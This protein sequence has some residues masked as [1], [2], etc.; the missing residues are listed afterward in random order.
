MVTVDYFSNFWEVDYLPDTKSTT[1][2]HKLKAHFAR[3]GIPDVLVSDNGP[4][5]TSQKFK[6][7][8]QKWEFEH[9][10]SSPGYPQSN[11]KAESAVKTAKRL[12]QRAAAAGQDPY[13]AILD[14]RN[15]PSQGLTTSPAQRLL[16]RRTRTLLPTKET[17]LK[18]KVTNNEQGLNNNRRRQEKYYNRTAKDLDCFNEGDSVRVQPFEP[19]K[20]WKVAKVIRP[21]SVRSYEVEL[22]SGGVVRRN[23]RHLRH[24]HCP[25]TPPAHTVTVTNTPP[26]VTAQTNG[27]TTRS[28]RQ[29]NR[30]SYLKDFTQ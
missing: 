1:V 19:C 2:I 27:T 10:T 23:R 12:M 14:H 6:T 13:L 22:E 24:N 21:V 17:L 4:Q 5:Y 18:P 7:F 3:Q 26:V 15:T 9:R 20:T 11:G 30:P 16:S 25:T 28:G 8:S 29:V